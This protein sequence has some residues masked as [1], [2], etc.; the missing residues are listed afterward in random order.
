M[1]SEAVHRIQH[2]LHLLHPTIFPFLDEE[3][4]T[5]ANSPTAMPP[6]LSGDKTENN[7]TSSKNDNKVNKLFVRCKFVERRNY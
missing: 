1:G 7:E 6:S 2:Q 4:I 3:G 5:I